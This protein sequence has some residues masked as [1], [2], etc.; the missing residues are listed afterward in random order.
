MQPSHTVSCGQPFRPWTSW[1]IFRSRAQV[2]WCIQSYIIS[3]NKHMPAH[4]SR[5]QGE[6]WAW[7]CQHQ[8]IGPIQYSAGANQSHH[9]QSVSQSARH[10]LTTVGKMM[11]AGRAASVNHTDSI[12]A[13]ICV[14]LP[15]LIIVGWRLHQS[16]SLDGFM[17]HNTSCTI[18][19][20][21]LLTYHLDF[22][23]E[24]ASNTHSIHY[25]HLSLCPQN[26]N[27]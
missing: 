18:F 16:L 6:R 5:T 26:S 1:E 9:L 22:P 19:P 10:T 11:T 15:V 27:F 12:S 7:A 3:G 20:T 25:T 4:P 21:E 24:A 14:H 13:C 23:Y 2:N 17:I 8:H